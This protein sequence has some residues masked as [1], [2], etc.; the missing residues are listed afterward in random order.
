MAGHMS[1]LLSIS[2]VEV[3]VRRSDRRQTIGLTVERDGS[4]V[5]AVPLSI[6]LGE[7]E[8]PLRGRD[9]WLHSA[10]TRRTSLMPSAPAKQYVSG[11]GFYCIGRA[12]RLRVLRGTVGDDQIPELRLFQGM[13]HLR[14]DCVHRGRECFVRWYSARAESWVGRSKIKCRGFGDFAVG[15]VTAHALGI[16]HGLDEAIK[17][18]RPGAVRPDGDTR[19][20]ARGGQ[21]RGARRRRG[22]A[23]FMAAH[24]R[25][26]LARLDVSHRAH[27]LDGEAVAV[28]RLEEDVHARR[29]AEVGRA[30]GFD[31]HG[32]EDAF[33]RIVRGE[34]EPRR[35]HLRL[36][37]GGHADDAE[38][39]HFAALHAFEAL[40]DIEQQEAPFLLAVPGHVARNYWR[41]LA[42]TKRNRVEAGNVRIAVNQFARAGR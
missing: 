28:E 14:W 2:N 25:E 9:L 11:E 31:R 41:S 36:S 1:E 23:M 27:G 20:L 17:A 30:V 38:R 19:R 24:T 12:Y 4:V 10:L 7:V 18:Q 29:Y 21:R 13:F 39:F 8:R 32:A 3:H 16:E 35:I 42:R 26:R 34:A 40:S 6:P 5:A 37:F 22:A 15:L 33:A